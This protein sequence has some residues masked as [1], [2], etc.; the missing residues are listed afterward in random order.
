MRRTSLLWALMLGGVVTALG[1]CPDP[2]TGSPDAASDMAA[3]TPFHLMGTVVGNSDAPL[4][5]ASVKVGTSVVATGNDGGFSATLSG[6]TYPVTLSINAAGYVPF[7]TQLTAESMNVKYRLQRLTEVSFPSNLFPLTISD[8]SSGALVSIPAEGLQAAGGAAPDGEITLA[9]RFID[10]SRQQIP[11]SDA[12]IGQKGEPLVVD[13]LGAIYITA[14]DSKG[15]SLQLKSGVSMSVVIPLTADR[16]GSAPTDAGLWTLDPV[17]TAWVQDV[18]TGGAPSSL[19]RKT[20]S[21]SCKDKQV[22]AC[23]ILHCGTVSTQAWMGQS[24][25]LGFLSAG[26]TFDKSACLRLEV[27]QPDQIC[28]RFEIPSAGAIKV[29][30]SCYGQGKHVLYNLAPNMPVMVKT[31]TQGASCGPDLSVGTQANP[32]DV[33]GGAGLPT[34]L[35]ACK[36]SLVIP[37]NP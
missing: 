18:N 37:P 32:G 21:F 16:A 14:R 33:W 24:S 11:G 34:D 3:A 22:D 20:T 27:N 29:K 10:P 8:P 7:I 36:G 6:V 30:E 4:V 25:S 1:G 31:R 23:D 9:L 5:N 2:E 17:K 15:T 13:S 12:A 35:S 26:T 28:L 19:Q